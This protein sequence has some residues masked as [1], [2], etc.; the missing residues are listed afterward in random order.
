MK[1]D[2]FKINFKKVWQYV[3]KKKCLLII[4]IFLNII[5]CAVCIIIPLISAKIILNITSGLFD[6]LLITAIMLFGIYI[7]EVIVSYFH[8]KLLQI[9]SRETLVNIQSD[10][11]KATL[12]LDIQIIDKN[13]SGMLLER[14]NGDC[15]KITSLFFDISGMLS[16]IITLI[17]VFI[18]ILVINKYMFIYMIVNSIIIFIINKKMINK[19]F[20]IDKNKRK[21]SEKKTSLISELVRGIRDIK[22]LNISDSF[23]KM[24]DEQLI[25]DNNYNYAMASVNRKLSYLTA[26]TQYLFSFLFIIFG[27]IL[28]KNN[29]LEISG[30]LIIYNY[31]NRAFNSLSFITRINE[32]LKDFNLSASRIFEIIDSKDF[33]KEKFGK[34]MIKNAE[35]HFKFENVNFS[36]NGEE[37][38]IKDLSFE[39]KPNETVAFVGKSGAG[40]TT[41]FSLLDKLYTID[42]GNIYIDNININDL[43]RDSIRNNISII[44][45]NPY[46]F[47]FSIRENLRLVRPNMTDEEMIEACRMACIDGALGDFPLE[48]NSLNMLAM[49]YRNSLNKLF[50]EINKLNNGGMNMN[51]NFNNQNINNQM[52]YDPNTG[53]PINN[54][55]NNFVQSFQDETMK[56][57]EK[58]CEIGFWLSILGLVCSLFGVTYGVIIYIMDFYFAS[59]GLKT[60]KRGKAIATIVLSIISILIVII[61][62]IIAANS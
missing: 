2:N 4:N 41:I 26:F 54:N 38:I 25:T 3:K 20:E 16:K 56:K 49:D 8:G 44:T 15:N 47:N 45:Q 10:L 61:E 51:N 23:E 28:C 59:Q 13:G 60:T 50:Q 18:S 42:S 57:K 7:I 40:K 19:R 12:N 14:I 37:K 62:L 35:G 5:Y 9:I 27:I 36:Y 1:K 34:K 32:S 52:N 21:F 53:Q 29:L 31:R 22:V 30:F 48:Q 6:E 39:I 24:L 58:M 46:I 55:D 17:G 11:A 33:K 43:D